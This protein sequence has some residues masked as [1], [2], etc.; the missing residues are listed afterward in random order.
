MN[1]S[2]ESDEWLN[3]PTPPPSPSDFIQNPKDSREEGEISPRSEHELPSLKQKGITEWISKEII[4]VPV[5][6]AELELITTKMWEEL[7]QKPSNKS[8]RTE[9]V[10]AFKL[11]RSLIKRTTIN[12]VVLTKSFK[13]NGLI[14]S[15]YAFAK[16]VNEETL[17]AQMKK[18]LHGRKQYSLSEMRRSIHEGCIRENV[19]CVVAL[20]ESYC[21]T[22]SDCNLPPPTGNS[23]HSRKKTSSSQL[24]NC[25]AQYLSDQSKSK[26]TTSLV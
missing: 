9:L 17:E 15:W 6:K 5:S 21:R 4:G 12:H 25:I 26:E 8:E 23:I 7:Y 11:H 1:S 20:A 18:L 2:P 22:C 3:S 10:Q 16:R 24:E 13:G 14:G 19:D